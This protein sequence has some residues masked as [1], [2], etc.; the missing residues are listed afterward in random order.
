VPGEVG[1]DPVLGVDAFAVDEQDFALDVHLLCQ[2]HEFLAHALKRSRLARAGL[3]VYEDIRWRLAPERGHQDFS[4]SVDLIHA[5][6]QVVR[7]VR[8]P[9]DFPVLEDRLHA[10]EVF[11][12]LIDGPLF[13]AADQIVEKSLTISTVIFSFNRCLF[14][15]ICGSDSLCTSGG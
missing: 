13:R 1:Q 14:H 5:V 12:Y 8:G 10:Q 2:V 3:A 4:H 7:S 15:G 6:G 9:E 11:E